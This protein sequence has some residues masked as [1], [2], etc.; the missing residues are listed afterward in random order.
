MSD[1]WSST[2]VS[3]ARPA[4]VL[5]EGPAYDNCDVHTIHGLQYVH[6]PLCIVW[7]AAEYTYEWS[8]WGNRFTIA[9]FFID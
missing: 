4:Y 7:L 8:S 2:N 9:I 1:I 5:P 6:D 3:V